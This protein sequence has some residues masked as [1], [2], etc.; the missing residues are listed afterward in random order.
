VR[1]LL[2]RPIRYIAY[3]TGMYRT[4]SAKLPPFPTEYYFSFTPMSHTAFTI[5]SRN[6][7][8]YARTLGE[9][10]TASN[11]SISFHVLVVDRKDPVFAA[12]NADLR[13]TWVEDLD[14]PNFEHVAFKY[15][16]LELN[17]N[18]KPTFVQRLLQSYDKVVYLDPDIFVYS[19]L[20]PIY[21]LLDEHGV[22]LTPHITR[23]IDDDELPS[24]QEFMTSGIYNLGFA[25]FNRSPEAAELLAWWER[26]CLS[27][28]YNE[29]AQGLF[30]D[31]KWMDFAPS[32]CSTTA[33]LREPQYNMAYWN[34]HERQI[35]WTDGVPYAN[36]RPLV[37]FHFSGLPPAE[38]DRVS[39]YQTRFRLGQRPDLA[40]LFEAYRARLANNGH[41]EYL[42]LP[43]GFATFS[44]GTPLTN[45]ARRV[46]A[47]TL[48]F[49]QADSP[50][51]AAGSLFKLLKASRLL[52]VG[53]SGAKPARPATTAE[54]E[55]E[56]AR[57]ERITVVALRSLLRI[58]GPLRYERLMRYTTRM[59]NLRRQTFLLAKAR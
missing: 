3:L 1:W 5:V 16:I 36:G 27:L 42:K 38:D 2:N 28:A 37:F 20:Q 23:P 14:I 10:L 46:A 24:E 6:Y 8:A 11:P 32:L 35:S 33:I 17:T 34:M 13:I 7:F 52:Q 29:Q 19:S 4:L 56:S 31:Q 44:D 22:V 43:Y 21:D 41:S 39:K 49:D 59:A 9:S 26:R 25:A 51:N 15:D 40:P 12:Q 53:A 57:L 45:V 30:V 50:F 18:V 54:A 48:A 55:V 58:F 47:S